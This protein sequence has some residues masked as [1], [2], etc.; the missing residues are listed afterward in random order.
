MWADPRGAIPVFR[1]L[2][3]TTYH[4]S[5]HYKACLLLPRV[6]RVTFLLRLFF[7]PQPT[8]PVV[9]PV[10]VLVTARVCVV[11]APVRVV[12][13]A[14]ASVVTSA[15]V[16]EPVNAVPS[17]LHAVSSFS[18]LNLIEPFSMVN[19]NLWDLFKICSVLRMSRKPPDHTT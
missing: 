9:H 1:V 12:T 4:G 6:A 13:A 5:S 18:M 19:T 16:P 3:E 17:A 10:S 14:H 7:P 8:V 11:P 2:E 15:S